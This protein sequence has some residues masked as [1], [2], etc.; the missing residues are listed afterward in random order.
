MLRI[1][2]QTKKTIV[3]VRHGIDEADFFVDR[4]AACLLIREL[5]QTDVAA[6]PVEKQEGPDVASHFFFRCLIKSIKKSQL[7]NY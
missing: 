2:K 7:A 4:V 3:F 5:L 1:W 6:A